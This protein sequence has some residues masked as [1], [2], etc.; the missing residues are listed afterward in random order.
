MS[1][2]L[3]CHPENATTPL[4]CTTDYREV[5]LVSVPCKEHLKLR[6]SQTVLFHLI[7]LDATPYDVIHH[8]GWADLLTQPTGH[9]QPAG[10]G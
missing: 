10:K 1:D 7:K 4:P 2:L 3:Q 6:P 8:P 5:Y 9:M